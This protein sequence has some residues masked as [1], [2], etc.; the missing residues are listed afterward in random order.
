MNRRNFIANS[1]MAVGATLLNS[2]TILS[3][4]TVKVDSFETNQKPANAKFIWN[5]DKNIGRNLYG[6][7]V[8][9]VELNDAVKE[10]VI[11]IFA[12]TSYQI[13]INGEF[14]NQ[15]PLRFDPRF[16]VFDSLDIKSYLKKGENIIAVQSNYF[17]MKTYKSIQNEAGF[18]A[19]GEIKTGKQKISLHTDDLNWICLDA[20][21]RKLFAPKNSFALNPID[22]FDQKGELKNWKK[23]FVKSFSYNKPV[24]CKDQNK[25]G[26]FSKRALPY[27]DFKPLRDIDLVHILPLKEDEDIYSFSSPIIDFYED[28]FDHHIR[29]PFS[30][31]IYSDK[32]QKVSVTRFWGEYWLNNESIESTEIYLDDHNGKIISQWELKKG[33]NY[34]FGSVNPYIDEV[35]IYL[36]FP[37]DSGVTIRSVKDL[38]ATTYFNYI[39][40][41]STDI[42]YSSI[43]TRTEPFN[44]NETLSEIGGWKK[45]SSKRAAMNSFFDYGWINFGY[46]KTN[47]NNIKIEQLKLPLSD[48]PFGVNILFD[49]KYTHLAIPKLKLRGVKNAIIDINYGELL[50]NDKKHIKQMFN[51]PIGDKIFCSEDEIE[52]IPNSSRGFRYV[53][54]TIK[55]ISSENITIDNLDF[56]SANYPLPEI[57]YLQTSDPML[58][59]IWKMCALTQKANVED[60]YDDCVMRERGMYIRDTVIQ[61]HNNLALSGD[62]ALMKRCLELYAQSADETGKFRAVF[63]NTGNYTIADFCLNAIDGFKIYLEQTNDEAFINKVWPDLTKNMLW[64]D[65]LSE[66]RA[67][68]LLDAD[69]NSKKGIEGHYGGFHGDLGIKNNYLDIHGIHCMFSCNY[70]IA[71]K[72]M[73]EMA[74]QLKKNDYVSYCTPKIEKL[75]KNIQEK[76]WDEKKKCFADN[77]ERTTYSAH[78]NIFASLAGVIKDEEQLKLVKKHVSYELRSLFVNGFSPSEGVL[79]SPSFCFYIFEGLYKL[80]LYDTAEKL[81]RDGWGWCLMQGLKTAPEYFS[82]ESGLSLCHAWSA[83]PLYFLSKN[84]LGIDFVDPLNVNKINIKVKTNSLAYAVGAYPHPKGVIKVKWHKSENGNLVYDS[85]D[86]PQGVE[87]EIV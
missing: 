54:I 16:P 81:M 51:N 24:I 87:Y 13:F 60:A 22:V 10:A 69:W 8:K 43:A 18:V 40:T 67:D 86:V 41:P 62:H 48:Y 15:G 31:Y 2:E 28:K 66:E 84:V 65:K 25:W 83:S 32:D 3:N 45:S 58:D 50:N 64:F 21:E 6:N 47:I 72:K 73:R 5:S 56:L 12:D 27:F 77:L 34:L 74:I 57:G 61:Y 20:N 53:S 82:F 33:W 49:L 68:L 59:S 19:W 29:V 71:L 79:I 36:G 52:Y 14:I 26:E 17:G 46:P 39:D 11:N 37:K 63:P 30:T 85:I 7:F 35:N 75:T 70:L 1:S 38:N 80:E 78:A 42:F 76:F 44:E 4:S 23:T 55:N 9:K